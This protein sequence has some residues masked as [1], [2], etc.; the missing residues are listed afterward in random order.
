MSYGKVG[1]NRKGLRLTAF[2]NYTSAEAPNLLLPD[3]ATGQPLQLDF[4]TP[5]FDLEV[6][7]SA[8]A[9]R[10]HLLTYGGNA[11]RNNFDI[12]IAPDAQ[13]RSE[14]GGYLQ[15]EI[16][17]DPVRITAGARVDKFGNLS[18]PV[19]SPRLSATFKA[20]PEHALRVSFNRAFRS[21][22]VVNNYI[23]IRIVAPV[24]L[25]ELAP[26]LP[27]ALQPLV[28][29]PFPLVVNAVGSELP[30]NGVPQ[31]ELTESSLTSYEVAYTGTVLPGT[32]VTGA[33]YVNKVS[34][35]INFAQLPPSLDPY[36]AA[37]PPPGWQLPPSVLTLLAAQGIF[38][39][40]TAFTY[41][42]L[43]PVRQRGL[44]LSVDQRISDTSSAFV[45]YSW[46]SEPRRLDDANPFPPLELALPPTHRI[47]A[48]FNVNG[49]RYVAS[50]AVNYSG[51]AL[52]SDVLTS[53]YHGF[54]DAFTLVNGTFGR[55]W[56][57]GKV[58]TSVK[59]TN[60]LN[61]TIQQ[62]IF[63]DLLKRSVTAEVRLSY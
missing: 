35:E 26:L 32:T 19:F 25:R 37:D 52:W 53:A 16:F 29:S 33:F 40:R 43:G 50:G 60:I 7:D 36:T 17:L 56:A 57:D 22:S 61:D 15:D 28:A 1:F 30:I 59:A 14:F 20:A 49:L 55:K 58:T 38:L 5:T 62:H 11:R 8:V 31:E 21:P 47:N 45:N 46:Q 18:N 42:N 48:G 9:S 34:D 54:T 3:P 6:S 24:N 63:G 39:P 12:T 2:A 13:N 10:R 27:P 51:R 23:D 41:L 4:K 44:E